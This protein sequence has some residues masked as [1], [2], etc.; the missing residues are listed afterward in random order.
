MET[1][2]LVRTERHGDVAV[3]L[4]DHPPVNAL[5]LAVRMGLLAAVTA[6]NRDS[7]VRAG[8]IAC[9]GRTFIAGGDIREFDQPPADILTSDICAA[10]DA[11]AKPV[12]AALHGSAL[13]GGFE[14]ALACH[15]RVLAPDAVVGFPEVRLGLIPGAGG[16]QRLP[17]LV[18]ALVALDIVSSGRQV[19]ADEALA[20]GLV[21]E[22]ATEPRR[23]AMVRAR[24]LAGSGSWGR[25]RDRPVPPCDREAF[26]MAVA[27]ARKRARGAVAPVRAAEA[28]GWALDQPFDVAAAREKGVSLGLRSGPQSRA[29]RGLFY[30]ERRAGR[31]PNSAGLEARPWPLRQ[32]GVAGGGAMGSGIAVAVAD[33]GLPVTVLEAG[34]ANRRAA[35]RRIAE[36]YQR[37]PADAAHADR[38]AR[39][40][41]V[42]DPA[43]LGDADLVVEAVPEDLSLKQEVFRRL[44]AVVRRDCV[45]ASNTSYLGIDAL[46][47]VVDAPERVI[48]LH[49]FNPVPLM[50]LVELARTAR[51]APEAA[52]TALAAVRR[53]GKLPVVC[54]VTEGCIGNRLLLRWRRQCDLMLE[55][56]ALPEEV[57]AALEAYG[58][59]MGPYAA[60]DQAGL[61]IGR[62]GRQRLDDTR[63]RGVPLLDWLCDHGRIGQKSGAG[64]YR[65]Q[66]GRRV[67]D[68]WVAELVGRASAARGITRRTVPAEEI[69]WRAHAA[70]VNEAARLVALGVAQRPSDIDVVMVHGYGYPAW[71]GGPMREADAIGIGQV[72]RR[73]ESLRESCG[74]GWEPAALLRELADAGRSFADLNL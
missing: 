29:L 69:Q 6:L 53:L 12:V 19:G 72:L 35:E 65:Y 16:T 47:G 3:I 23:V 57:D 60:A 50:R 24:D 42:A 10:L 38:L 1:N 59:P 64:W 70:I 39:I 22:I 2:P 36:H 67:P 45:L 51:T 71:R 58:F 49:F 52:A 62:I 43:D 55:E 14:V 34:E 4:I 30:A 13:G 28:V 17:R 63:L 73:V 5:S 66:D 31:L 41:V 27:N 44:A 61:D 74:P 25:L 68:P 48:G 7:G 46:A 21:D 8:V 54:G 40:R 32:F 20:L 26:A 37:R 11:S 9:A 18:G 33:A 15:G 56:G